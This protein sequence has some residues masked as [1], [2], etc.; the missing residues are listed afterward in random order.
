MLSPQDWATEVPR[1]TG[2]YEADST[3]LGDFVG[4]AEET[5][6]T[7]PAKPERD[8][9]EARTAHAV[10]A[11][12]QSARAAFLATH[13]ERLYE[14][15]TGGYRDHPRLE[16]LA[17]TAAELH[18]GLV[19]DRARLTADNGLRQADKEGREVELGLFFGALLGRRRSG[20]HLVE[21][22]L[23]P[24]RAAREALPEFLRTGTAD[25]GQVLVERVGP[26]AHLTLR[27]TAFLN[28][29]DDG[30]VE[31]LE[32]AV[33][34]A[35]LDDGIRVGVLRGGPM[36]HPRYAGQR[37][38]SAGI[39]LT[40]LH[41]GRITLLGFML[42]RELGYLSKILRGLV[43][44][45]A[46]G[47]PAQRVEKPW[48]A[49]VDSFAIGGGLQQLLVF[50]EVIAAEG[51]RFSLPALTEGIIPGA[52]NLR[53]TRFAGPR[54]ARQLTFRNRH[55]STGDPEAALFCDEVCAPE[56]LPEAAKAAVERLADHAVAPNR[57]LLH[58]SEEP[59]DSFRDYIAGYAVEQSRLLH[60]PDLGARLERTWVRR[61]RAATRP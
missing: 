17:A 61:P 53:L 45:G 18:P 5:L 30:T 44:D 1:I 58:Q 26:A 4:A 42:R 47:G 36:E 22:M 32:T 20:V 41:A 56:E 11:A 24:T 15:L 55:I 51:S 37:V 48:L 33:D 3:L 27:N 34:L 46:D 10:R 52:A 9:G 39:N 60:H 19:P 14:D 43:P 2:R 49:L 8:E 21:S 40:H 12:C 54:L 57:R 28:A 16:G 6:A 23:R 25:L 29:E 31:A 13:A 59:L 7:L 38:F 50:D 35:L